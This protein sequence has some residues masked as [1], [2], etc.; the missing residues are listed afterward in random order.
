MD[1]SKVILMTD[2]DGT[3][4]TD[5]KEILPVDMA[6][7][8]R[9]RAGGGIF[10]MAT[11]RGYSMARSVAEKLGLDVPAVIFNGAAVFDFSKD[12]FLWRSEI[13]AHARDYIK[14][15][16][17]RFPDIGIEVLHEQTVF[18][19]FLNETEQWHLDLEGVVPD[20]TP[21]DELPR[22][23]WLKVLL[24]YPPERMDEVV[25]FIQSSDMTGA[26]WV[27]SAPMF[28]ECL[29]KGIDKSAGFREL[30]RLL[31]AEDRFTAA[32]GDFM[33]DSAMIREA[34]LGAAVAS[35]QP[36]VKAVADIVV[37]DNNSGAIAEIIDYI[38]RM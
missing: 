34:D 3:L 1:F 33:N 30:I 4:L 14:C 23:G 19:P 28:Y 29:P 6:A 31:N 13:G 17:A 8:E 22:D 2:L 7:I 10:T 5:S 36:E 20:L 12:K 9:F 18:V 32:A 26:Q 15:I 16:T 35:A 21:L 25:E 37:C 38:E 27:R 11:G 24:A